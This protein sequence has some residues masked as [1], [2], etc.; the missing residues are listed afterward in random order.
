MLASLIHTNRGPEPQMDTSNANTKPNARQLALDSSFRAT[1]RP[2]LSST[3]GPAA[4]LIVAPMSL[5]GQWKNELERSSKP[6]TIKVMIWH[7]TTRGSLDSVIDAGG[8][9]PVDVVITSYGTL[10]SEH[11]KWTKMGK[12]SS[13][14][15]DGKC[16]TFQSFPS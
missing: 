5:L 2:R 14:V 1:K 6:G 3:T 4:T 10:A 11:A 9:D 12:G 13:P 16:S 7:G 15:Y 8:N